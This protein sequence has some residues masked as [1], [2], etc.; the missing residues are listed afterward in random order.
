MHMQLHDAVDFAAATCCPTMV[1]ASSLVAM[2]GSLLRAAATSDAAASGLR[3]HIQLHGAVPMVGA[4]S[5]VVMLGSQLRVATI[6]DAAADG[7]RMHMQQHDTVG[8]A[9][10]KCR[11]TMVW[12]M[13]RDVRPGSLSRAATTSLQQWT[14]GTTR[15]LCGA[16]VHSTMVSG[17]RAS[18]TWHCRH[19][20]ALF[21]AA[22]CH[23]AMAWASSLVALLGSLLRAATNSVATACGLDY[24]CPLCDAI[25][26]L[27]TF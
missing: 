20:I 21:A 22:T 6:S 23:F 13:S 17:E 18:D 5:L 15:S 4:F 7:L 2:L 14:R 8:S 11:P 25:V 12:V 3:I 26:I 10:A 16:L 27:A 24:R 1:W 9:A 19:H